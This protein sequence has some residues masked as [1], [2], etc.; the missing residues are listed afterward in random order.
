MHGAIEDEFGGSKGRGWLMR[1]LPDL[2]IDDGI[3]L[4][5][6]TGVVVDDDELRTGNAMISDLTGRILAET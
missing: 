3:F 6:S 2:C 1:W 4:T 5:F